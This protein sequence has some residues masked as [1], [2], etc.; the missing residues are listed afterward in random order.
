MTPYDRYEADF[1]SEPLH[2]RL[3]SFMDETP[4]LRRVDQKF[5]R[6]YADLCERAMV[7]DRE[8]DIIALRDI[9]DCY[10]ERYTIA[11]DIL[12]E[13]FKTGVVSNDKLAR[14]RQLLPE[15]E[16]RFLMDV[17]EN[18]TGQSS[19]DQG[20]QAAPPLSSETELC[21]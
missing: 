12:T 5:Y 8:E 2:T 16:Y 1:S 18:Y 11:F 4:A 20:D 7:D 3:E 19:G 21:F 13:L 15:D 14:G 10:H 9:E 6:S 17:L